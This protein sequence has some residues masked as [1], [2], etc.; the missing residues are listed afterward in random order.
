MKKHIHEWSY[1]DSG[2][3]RICTKCNI[4]INLQTVVNRVFGTL[5]TKEHSHFW[6]YDPRKFAHFCGA[7]GKIVDGAE[8]L[9]LTD[10]WLA[11]LPMQTWLPHNWEIKA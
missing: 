5:D 9:E 8:V 11:N 6:E 4:A 1:T 2:R 10:K 7:C 3:Q